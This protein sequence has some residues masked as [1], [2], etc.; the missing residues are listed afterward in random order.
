MDKPTLDYYA[1]HAS[2]VAQRYEVAPSPLAHRF[3]ESFTSGGRIL[4]IGCGSG[5]DLA[6]LHKQGFQPYGVDGTEEFVQ[7]AQILHPELKGRV[8]QGLL[9]DLSEPFGDELFDGVL[10]C[11]VLMHIDSTELFNAALS[12]K[13]CLKVNGRLLISVPSQ[14]S[15]TGDGERDANGRLFKTYPSAYLRLIFERLGFSLIGEWGN[16]DAM[17]RQGIE[18]VSLLFQLRSKANTRPIDQIEGVL[19]HDMKAATY[20]FALLRALAEIAT[21]SPNSVS[22]LG[23]G[24]VSLPVKYVAEKWLQYYWPLIESSVFMP[25]INAE[26]PDSKIFIKFRRSLTELISLYSKVGGFSSFRIERNKGVLSVSK[27]KLLKRVM[28]DISSAIVTGP[29]KHSGGALGTGKVF[30]YHSATKSVLMPNDLWIELSQL[31]YW[32]SQAVILQWAEKTTSL[33]K[34]INVGEVVRLLLDKEDIRS[35][36]AARKLF[37][38]FESLQCVW[39]GKSLNAKFEVDHVIPFDLWHNNDSWNLLPASKT[40]NS[41]KSNKLPSSDLL[42]KRKDHIVGYWE[43]ILNLEVTKFKKEA[44]TLLVLPDA[45]WQNA[46]FS[47]LAGAIEMTAL[48]RGVKRWPGL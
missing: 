44:E 35:T 38:N 18:W 23:H 36:D 6:Q 14:R 43:V 25:Q 20:K 4:D 45:N 31:G 46:L 27:Q 37:S 2:E 26:A 10:C 41:S 33:S 15:D 7:L 22:W 32:V 13:R 29:I 21:Q 30:K 5:R 24:E 42:K 19:N 39:S 8:V 12:I 11:A 9:P 28:S 48:Q 16:S 3:A 17:T 40:A 34:G 47:E 1:L